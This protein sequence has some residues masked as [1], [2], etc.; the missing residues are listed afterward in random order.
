[1]QL[2]RQKPMAQ[3]LH[4]LDQARDAG[5]GLGVADVGLHRSDQQRAIRRALAEDVAE[6]VHLDGIAERGAG[7]VRLDKGNVARL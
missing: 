6:R 7:A 4:R 1:M 2:P 3:R 5:S